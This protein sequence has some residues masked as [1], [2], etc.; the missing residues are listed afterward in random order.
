MWPSIYLC[1]YLLTY[2]IN[3]TTQCIRSNSYWA[4]SWVL[5]ENWQTN[6][7]KVLLSAGNSALLTTSADYQTC[8]TATQQLVTYTQR[9]MCVKNNFYGVFLI[10]VCLSRPH[11]TPGYTRSLMRCKKLA[12]T[13]RQRPAT[14]MHSF[15]GSR[16]TVWPTSSDIK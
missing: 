6:R 12:A 1:A 3:R 2:G 9:S 4:T 13:C 16:T 7:Y 8:N 11:D 5:N 14:L 15:N 10:H